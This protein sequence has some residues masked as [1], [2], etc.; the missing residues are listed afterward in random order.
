MAQFRVRESTP[1]NVEVAKDLIREA[2]SLGADVVCLPELFAYRY[3]PQRREVSQSALQEYAHSFN[4]VVDELRSAC[5]LYGVSLVAGSLVESDELRYYNT[6]VLIDS[7]GRVVGKYRKTHIPGDECY[8][9]DLYFTP[10]SSE[11]KPFQLHG[12][13]VGALICFDQWFP[14]P[15]RAYTLNGAEVI[16]YPTAIGWVSGIEQ[17]EGDW[18]DAWELVQ[19][20]HAVANSVLVVTVNRTGVEGRITFWGSSFIADQFGCVIARMGIE[21][22]GVVVR[23]TDLNLGEKIREGWRFLSCRR[24]ELYSRVA[25]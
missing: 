7:S 14:E 23:R 20:G 4:A 24:P 9:E 5:R 15:V 21:E 11:F 3:F 6:S 19:R 18:K 16:F 1:K 10:G 25:T 17:T 22:E 8:H 2:S 12:V 13:N